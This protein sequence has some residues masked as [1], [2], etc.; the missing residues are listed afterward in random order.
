M[1]ALAKTQIHEIMVRKKYK[2]MLHQH[3]QTL[4]FGLRYFSAFKFLLDLIPLI[5][6]VYNTYIYMRMNLQK[7][8][9]ALPSFRQTFRP[10]HNIG[11]NLFVCQDQQFWNWKES[12]CRS[13][14]APSNL[15][16]R[17]IEKKCTIN[18]S[19]ISNILNLW[20][21]SLQRAG[22]KL[23]HTLTKCCQQMNLQIKY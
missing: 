21:I 1:Q 12:V 15:L 14:P 20:T 9:W 4:G 22:I 16:K 3:P 13:R 23:A 17:S 19:L 2:K 10:L 11:K 8:V 18:F 7:Y 6:C 5:M